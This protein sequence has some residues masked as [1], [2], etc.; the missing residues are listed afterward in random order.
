MPDIDHV[1]YWSSSL[2]QHFLLVHCV[3]MFDM[4][5]CSDW[6]RLYMSSAIEA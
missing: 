5:R 1:F 6:M 4:G 2:R 3:I